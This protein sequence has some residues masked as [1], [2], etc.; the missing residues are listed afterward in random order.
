MVILYF[1][2]H[3]LYSH[4][5]FI[6]Y[7][8]IFYFLLD[9]ENLP[10]INP[11]PPVVPLP[12]PPP[13]PIE[14]PPGPGAMPGP[15]PL[16]EIAKQELLKEVERQKLEDEKNRLEEMNSLKNNL[17]ADSTVFD[18]R[19]KL[20]T[21]SQRKTKHYAKSTA[22]V[23]IMNNQLDTLNMKIEDKVM[24]KNSSQLTS[25]LKK[26]VSTKRRINANLSFSFDVR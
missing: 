12:P 15:G 22:L 4:F 16:L 25:A 18:R 3:L 19:A 23:P 1:I 7:I 6:F 11:Q 9:L 5:T 10:P 20:L 2:F 24:V 8:F 26:P 21:N 17:F 14:A 13:K